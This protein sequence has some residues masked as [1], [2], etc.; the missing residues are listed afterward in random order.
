[1]ILLFC[2][3]V[4]SMVCVINAG[5]LVAISTEISVCV[6]AGTRGTHNHKL[7]EVVN[8]TA[9]F[10]PNFVLTSLLL[11]SLKVFIHSL[12]LCNTWKSRDQ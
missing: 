4:Y 8:A 9:F 5:N 3:S 7:G 11:H 12:H 2:S 6:S 10:I 1:M